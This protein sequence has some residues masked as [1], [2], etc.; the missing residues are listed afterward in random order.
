MK[1][2]LSDSLQYRCNFRRSFVSN[3][4]SDTCEVCNMELFWDEDFSVTIAGI[5]EDN[6][7][8]QA[9]NSYSKM[10]DQSETPHQSFQKVSSAGREWCGA[11]RSAVRLHVTD[12][13]ETP[14]LR[15]DSTAP[16]ALALR[17]QLPKAHLHTARHLKI[18]FSKW[19][20]NSFLCLMINNVVF[21]SV[22]NIS[23]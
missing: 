8:V 3:Y 23:S 21:F 12:S 4:I 20:H 5:S 15:T 16:A 13:T 22:I 2:N 19:C 9:Q 18:A 17:N 7:D 10:S 1:C 6:Q 14:A 11:G